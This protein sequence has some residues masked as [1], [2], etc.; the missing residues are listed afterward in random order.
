MPKTNEGWTTGE[1]VV[2]LA[3]FSKPLEALYQ[4]WEDAR[5]EFQ[6]S[7]E[8]ETARYLRLANNNFRR[9]CAYLRLLAKE[10]I[11]EG[12]ANED[13]DILYLVRQ[14][15]SIIEEVYAQDPQTLDQSPI[16]W[17]QKTPVEKELYAIK[18][19]G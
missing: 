11:K 19:M 7:S 17:S 14:Q 12:Y 16:Q 8:Y 9:A 13:I 5:L 18:I 15:V 4:Q 1:M 3:S 10:Y 6:D 2:N